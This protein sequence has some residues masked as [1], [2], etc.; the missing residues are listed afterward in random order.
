MKETRP[1]HNIVT[2]NPSHPL[3]SSVVPLKQ[4]ETAKKKKK[5]DHLQQT[6]A[7]DLSVTI[8]VPEQWPQARID[9]KF[10]TL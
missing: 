2:S 6:Q 9:W 3:S 5:K 1:E 7:Q 8:V 4:T 10:L